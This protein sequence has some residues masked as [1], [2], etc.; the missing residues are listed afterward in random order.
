MT[1]DKAGGARPDFCFS[2]AI[3]IKPGWLSNLKITGLLLDIDNTITRWEQRIVPDAE[4][5]WLNTLKDQGISLLLLSNG[6]AGKKAQVIAQSGLEH[7][8]G[9]PVKPLPAAFRQGLIDLQLPANQVMMVGDSI[10]TDII[11][12][13][14]LGI[15]TAL[16]EPLGQ[17]DFPG[18][19]LYRLLEQLLRLR[20]PLN[21]AHD[22]RQLNENGEISSSTPAS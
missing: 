13:N 7:V 3:H 20:R 2:R 8:S 1:N 11:P 15:W 12:A 19:K 4:L 9:Y 14:R 16:V 10:F 17:V 21:P 5:H 22:F 6:L 18:T